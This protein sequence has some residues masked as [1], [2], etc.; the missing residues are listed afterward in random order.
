MMITRTHAHEACAALLRGMLP[1]SV[2]GLTLDDREQVAMETAGVHACM[3]NL[4]QPTRSIFAFTV[5]SS[6]LTDRPL[7]DGSIDVM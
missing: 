1:M 7:W 5:A 3:P 2:C 6:P 4:K